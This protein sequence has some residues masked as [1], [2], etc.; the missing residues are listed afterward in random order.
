MEI[1][2]GFFSGVFVAVL[3][4]GWILFWWQVGELAAKMVHKIISR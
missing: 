2:T 3:T 1:L 4:M